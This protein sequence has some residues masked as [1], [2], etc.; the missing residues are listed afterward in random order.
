[1][2]EQKIESATYNNG[3]WGITITGQGWLWE[4]KLTNKAHCPDCNTTNVYKRGNYIKGGKRYE[5]LNDK[6]KRCMFIAA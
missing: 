3:E 1:M 2:P 4:M 6:C 5:C